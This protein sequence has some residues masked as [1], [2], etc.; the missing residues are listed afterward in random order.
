MGDERMSDTQ[1]SVSTGRWSKLRAEH[2][3]R[4]TGNGMSF[5][6]AMSKTSGVGEGLNG[7]LAGVF[8]P[9]IR[10]ACGV[11]LHHSLAENCAYTLN[12]ATKRMRRPERR[13]RADP[14]RRRPKVRSS[15]ALAAGYWHL[16]ARVVGR[17]RCA[18]VRCSRRRVS[19]SWAAGCC[20]EV[21]RSCR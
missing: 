4:H 5:V 13:C 10:Q 11:S 9:K 1:V 15:V 19:V 12:R 8:G 3:V 21:R 16:G 2:E 18:V 14:V 6:T 7:L 17:Q 20:A